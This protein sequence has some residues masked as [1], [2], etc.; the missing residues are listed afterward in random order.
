MLKNILNNFFKKENPYTSKWNQIQDEIKNCKQN[1]DFLK[2]Q[3][4]HIE[5]QWLV[6]IRD[7][8][9]NERVL[10]IRKD[11]DC[12]KWAN[13]P[14][15]ELHKG[16][17]SKKVFDQVISKYKKEDLVSPRIFDKKNEKHRAFGLD[18]GRDCE[19]IMRKTKFEDLPMKQEKLSFPKPFIYNALTFLSEYCNYD[20]H[21]IEPDYVIEIRELMEEFG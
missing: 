17:D 19:V 20:Q 3:E 6:T 7:F 1:G 5:L 21:Y 16:I 12:M 10:Q 11:E 15:F 14:V 18:V 4:L 2:L 8:D 13:K 9:Y